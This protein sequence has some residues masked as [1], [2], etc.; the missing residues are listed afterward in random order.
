MNNKSGNRH[1]IDILFVLT[2]FCVFA[3]SALTLVTLGADIYQQTVD[4]METN[5][6]SRTP[7]SY[8]TQKIRQADRDDAVWVDQ[9]EEVPAIVL[10]QT[11]NQED[12]YTYL[13][14]YNGFLTELFVRANQPLSPSAGNPIVEVKDFQIKETQSNLFSINITTKSDEELQLQIS[15][16]CRNED[17]SY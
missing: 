6:E 16:R 7:Y 5:F 13:Y 15:T 14:A 9:L 12:Y 10:K 3:I 17:I 8:I 4:H 1:M 2:L 11:I